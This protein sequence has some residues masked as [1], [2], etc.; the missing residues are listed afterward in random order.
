MFVGSIA[1]I[2]AAYVLRPHLLRRSYLSLLLFFFG[3]GG[4]SAR[5]SHQ[6]DKS[7]R[8]QPQAAT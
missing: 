4:R 1:V 6:E 8:K 7:A 2:M 5:I 3:S